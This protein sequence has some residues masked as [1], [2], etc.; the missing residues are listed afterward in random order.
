MEIFPNDALSTDEVTALLCEL[1]EKQLIIRYEVDDERYFRITGF[2]RH[3]RIDQPT[4]R[5]PDE[6]GVLRQIPNRR[7]PTTKRTRSGTRKKKA[8]VHV[9]VPYERIIG[10]YHEVLPDLDRVILS[11]WSKSAGHRDLK[12]RWSEDQKHQSDDFWRWFFAAAK[13]NPFWMGQNDSGWSANLR[14][15]LKR[16]NFDKVL[17]RGIAMNPQ[18]QRS[19]EAVMQ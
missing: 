3:Q 11:R 13:S 5:Y 9:M 6:G 16:Q 14:W 2:S 15:L 4:Y 7:R 8:A 10:L 1:E 17:E 12:A 18:H 19:S